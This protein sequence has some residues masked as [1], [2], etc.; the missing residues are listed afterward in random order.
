MNTMTVGVIAATSKPA[1]ETP[2][3]KYSFSKE[4]QLAA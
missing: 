3:S 1:G 4:A 2:P